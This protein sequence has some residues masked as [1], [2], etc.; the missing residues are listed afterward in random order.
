MSQ[1]PEA[2]ILENEAY[3]NNYNTL[4][5]AF[6]NGHTCVMDCI[7]KSTGE[8]VPVICAIFKDAENM[9]NTVPF[10]MMFTGNPYEMLIS[11][12]EYEG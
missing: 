11:P 9:I 3:I 1:Q 7:I 12:L 2:K 10:A 6:E 5:K 4:R 8:H